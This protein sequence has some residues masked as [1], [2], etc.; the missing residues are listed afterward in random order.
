M[1]HIQ[2]FEQ[3]IFENQLFEAT[4]EAKILYKKRL[5]SLKKDTL[6]NYINTRDKRDNVFIVFFQPEAINFT[7]PKVDEFGDLD[8]D[9]KTISVTPIMIRDVWDIEDPYPNEKSF[10]QNPFQSSEVK[11]ISDNLVTYNTRVSK[12]LDH[13]KKAQPLGVFILKEDEKLK[14]AIETTL[15]CNVNLLDAKEANKMLN[16][17]IAAA[18]KVSWINKQSS[19]EILEKE[20]AD[21]L[22]H[23]QK[24]VKSSYQDGV[25]IIMDVVSGFKSIYVGK[26]DIR[27]RI[28]IGVAGKSIFAQGFG[29]QEFKDTKEANKIITDL[30]SK[31]KDEHKTRFQTGEE[32]R[33]K[34]SLTR[35]AYR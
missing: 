23:A 29:I 28:E 13:F 12:H 24:L 7:M 25:S 26:T 30:V 35:D 2:T 21:I 15:G 1:K 10:Y 18:H 19:E 34:D 6:L 5:E 8:P 22:K 17:V 11:L 14:T 3:F 20:I 33:A 9:G 31:I 27:T 16:D 4:S 32:N